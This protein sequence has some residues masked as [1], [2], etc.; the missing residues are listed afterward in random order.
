[1]CTPPPPANDR[2]SGAI[3]INMGAPQSTFSVNTTSAN[4]DIAPPCV[5]SY[6]K[7]AYYVFTL[8]QREL[9]YAD[10]FGSSFD[11]LLFLASSCTSGIASSSMTNGRVCNDDDSSCG[12][13]QSRI[14]TVLGPGTYYLVVSGW[15]GQGGAAN[16]RFQHIPVGNSGMTELSAGT[17]YPSG[18]TSGSSAI[19]DCQGSNDGPENTYWWT[20]CPG[21]G[22]GTLSANTCSRASWDTVLFARNGDGSGGQC[23][24]DG[25]GAQS[26]ISFPV[27][28]GAGV[29]TLTIDGYYTW[30]YGSY[31]IAVT[32]P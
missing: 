15:A 9:V 19:W 4:T 2:C 31:S 23:N 32:R 8:S 18:S 16:V 6:G 24:D 25:C 30:S 20:T 22:G 21:S 27:A 13:L 28:S 14:T 3:A 1:V 29:H 10:T 26:N 7:D 17:T 12:S 11:T 5:G